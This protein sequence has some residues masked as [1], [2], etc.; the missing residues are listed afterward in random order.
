MSISHMRH[1]NDHE[2]TLS[3]TGRRLMISG[4]RYSAVPIKEHRRGGGG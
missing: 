4:G 3:H 2:S 1:P